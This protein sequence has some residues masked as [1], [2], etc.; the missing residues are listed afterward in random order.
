MTT[1]VHLLARNG[2]VNKVEFLGLT[3]KPLI[4]DALKS[5]QPPYSGQLTCPQLLLP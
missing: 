3:V 4:T 1:R 2:P 5:G